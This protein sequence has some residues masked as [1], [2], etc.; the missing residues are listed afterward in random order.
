MRLTAVVLLLLLAGCSR[1]EPSVVVYPER[2]VGAEWV[3]RW[4][5]NGL[6]SVAR[7]ATP[8]EAARLYAVLAAVM[9]R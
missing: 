5:Y 3:V 6:E 1:P 8:E 9:R 7:H 2:K 4:E